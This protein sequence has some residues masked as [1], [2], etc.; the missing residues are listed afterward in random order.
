MDNQNNEVKKV[1]FF[2]K[3]INWFLIFLWII[4]LI[5]WL[6]MLSEWDN[7]YWFASIIVWV[8][9]FPYIYNKIKSLLVWK[10]FAKKFLSNYWKFYFLTF[11]IVFILWVSLSNS[12]ERTIKEQSNLLV[13][14][15]INDE[16]TNQENMTLNLSQKY[17]DKISINDENINFDK[18]QEN[19][20]QNI[21]L[22][23][24]ENIILIKWENEF[25]KKD[26]SKTITR[27]SEEEYKSYLDQIEQDRI[28]KEK[29]EQERLKKLEEEKK[30]QQEKARKEEESKRNQ[31]ITWYKNV[32]VNT[33]P[34]IWWLSFNFSNI[35]LWNTFTYDSNWYEYSYNSAE[36]WEKYIT[37]KSPITSEEKNPILPLIAFYKYDNLKL[38][39]EWLAYYKFTKWKDYW[40]YLWNYHDNWNDFSYSETINFSIWWTI[41]EEVVNNNS[42]FV[43]LTNE[44]CFNRNEDVFWRPKVSYQLDYNCWYKRTLELKDL[45]E[46]NVIKIFNQNLIK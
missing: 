17:I 45:E 46:L 16:I 44:K 21:P 28:Q 41:N 19:I 11:F 13:S 20:S 3:I 2:Q 37:M 27:L 9:F 31:I 6:T 18:N 15:S 30:I 8:S 22:K 10:E 1:W 32:K 26:F 42:I 24:G 4:F 12:N 38:Q 29:E 35:Q 33:K 40:S 43:I 14:Y 25:Y 36:R 5:W 7:I 34:K 39:Y 23:L